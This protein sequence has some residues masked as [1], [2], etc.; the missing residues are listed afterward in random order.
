MSFFQ[1]LFAKLMP[2]KTMEAMEADSRD[3]MVQCPCGH[4]RSVWEMGGIR[5]GASS[6][7]KRT[8]LRCEKCGKRKWHRFYHKSAEQPRT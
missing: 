8:L 3:W 2:K 4:E 7:G 6:T 1:R 5:Y